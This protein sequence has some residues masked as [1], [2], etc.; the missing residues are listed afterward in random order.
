MV[1]G[2][3][4]GVQEFK[5]KESGARI[6]EPGDQGFGDAWKKKHHGSK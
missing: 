4:Q 3:V 1:E 6:Q 2:G 5:E